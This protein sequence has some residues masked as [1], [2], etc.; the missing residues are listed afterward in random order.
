MKAV[1]NVVLTIG[2][3]I[4]IIFLAIIILALILLVC[5]IFYYVKGRKYDK[6]EVEGRVRLLLGILSIAFNYD[7]NV[8]DVVVRI[9]GI[10]VKT[11]DLNSEDKETDED[12]EKFKN[13][14]TNK[15]T[16]VSE[17]SKDTVIDEKLILEM[18]Q[19]KEDT[20]GQAELPSEQTVTKVK[21]SDLE[22]ESKKDTNAVKR[23]KAPDD[24]ENETKEDIKEE[25]SES[26]KAEEENK[27]ENKEKEELNLKYFLKMPKEE[28]DRL[29]EAIG[30]YLKSIFK[31]VRPD[32]FYLMGTL[33][34]ED[35][36]I[37]GQVVGL[38]WILNGIL[39]KRI[40]IQAAFDREVIEGEFKISGHLVPAAFIYYTVRFILTKE[41][42][43]IIKLRMK[44][45]DKNVRSSKKS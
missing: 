15:T 33:G 3:I 6:V 20:W 22:I 13:T 11:M 39:N 21:L 28:R 5:P 38:A 41:V 2:K 10:K 42:M 43:K 45:R 16:E 1:L 37:T 9:F 12:F 30:K 36:S 31:G 23:I 40:E 44:G 26:K 17:G 34:F 18:Q 19:E 29:F 4:L 14:L 25:A 7:G 27:E 8:L 35:P 24:G 32:N